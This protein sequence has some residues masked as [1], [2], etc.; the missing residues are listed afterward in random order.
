MDLFCFC[1]WSNAV[2]FCQMTDLILQRKDCA[3][4]TAFC[5]KSTS[6][7]LLFSIDHQM[8]FIDHQMS[9]IDY[10]MICI[11]HQICGVEFWRQTVSWVSGGNFSALSNIR[12]T[13]WTQ[14][15]PAANDKWHINCKLDWINIWINSTLLRTASVITDTLFVIS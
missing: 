9:C 14:T 3:T 15:W 7:Q 6:C 12:L 11:D 2:R 5:N 8:I 13:A 10:Q 1:F 4:P